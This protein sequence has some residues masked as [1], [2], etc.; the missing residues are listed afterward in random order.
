MGNVAGCCCYRMNDDDLEPADLHL[1]KLAAAAKGSGMNTP[2][3]VSEEK[4]SEATV[5]RQ[6]A[7][8][9]RPNR[10]RLSKGAP[11]ERGDA[12]AEPHD[13]STSQRGAAAIDGVARVVRADTGSSRAWAVAVRSGEFEGST[14]SW[15]QLDAVLADLSAAM[16]ALAGPAG[17]QGSHRN[18]VERSSAREFS[19]SGGSE[20]KSSSWASSISEAEASEA[21]SSDEDAPAPG[22]SVFDTTEDAQSTL[23]DFSGAEETIPPSQEPSPRINAA[24]VTAAAWAAERGLSLEGGGMEEMYKYF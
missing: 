9:A 23:Q 16:A 4:G 3:K 6:I 8:V 19:P 17:D 22:E 1:L 12:S 10:R 18:I 15:A 20:Q 14:A 11:P 7:S 2:R 5:L 21:C 24:V 13:T